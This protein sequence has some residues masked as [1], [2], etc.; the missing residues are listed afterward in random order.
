MGKY[1]I[2]AAC[3]ILAYLILFSGPDKKAPTKTQATPVSS[4]PVIFSP[5]P[6]PA[7]SPIPE[8]TLPP[9]TPTPQATPE[10]KSNSVQNL[11]LIGTIYGGENPAALIEDVNG[12]S[13]TIKVHEK[14]LSSG[15]IVEKIEL[16][17]VIL[18]NLSN[19]KTIVLKLL[20]KKSSIPI[21]K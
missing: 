19:N 18:K 2:A 3:V 1:I 5:T 12:K 11:K 16:N 8:A 17:H 10:K 21:Q 15:Y 13:Y 9:P 14:V 20:R 6:A 7:S 4:T